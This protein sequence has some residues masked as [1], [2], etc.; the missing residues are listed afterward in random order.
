MN[1]SDDQSI[2]VVCTHPDDECLGA[3][4]TI[5]SHVNAGF[6]VDIL[7]LTS[8]A[9]RL[10]E[11]RAACQELGVTK[12]YA[13]ERDDFAV[14]LDLRQEVVDAILDSRPAIVITHSPEDYNVTHVVCSELVD[15]A[16]E[17]ASHA[18]IFDNAHRVDRI[19]QME[20]NSLISRP[21]VLVDI[22]DSYDT[23]LTALK[24][25]KSQMEKS[26][27]FYVKFYDARTH[28]RGVQGSCNRAEA[29]SIKL[30]FHAGPFYHENNVK[31]LI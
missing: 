25:H 6:Q 4:G 2:L 16:V 14:T 3:G 18:T 9:T 24:K 21:H 29:F 8:N 15:Q 5:S 12:I 27:G 28:L 31:K 22:S 10:S 1:S 30:P 26:D 11:L 7:C 17:W 13:T 23:A 20:I 19:Y